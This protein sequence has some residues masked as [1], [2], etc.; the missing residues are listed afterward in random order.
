MRLCAIQDVAFWSLH[1]VLRRVTAF[2]AMETEH[3]HCQALNA[4]FHGSVDEDVADPCRV[5]SPADP[6]DV[7]GLLLLRGIDQSLRVR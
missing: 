4:F 1:A 3:F 7:V 5:H 6:A 2:E